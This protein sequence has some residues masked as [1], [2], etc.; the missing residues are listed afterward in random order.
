MKRRLII[1]LLCCAAAVSAADWSFSG[2]YMYFDNSVTK[3]A[4]N[5]IMLIIGKGDYSSVYEMC[6]AP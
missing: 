2:G 6:P 1:L 4:D 3:W 5:S